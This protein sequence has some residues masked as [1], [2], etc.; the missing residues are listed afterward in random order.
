DNEKPTENGNANSKH[1][2]KSDEQRD[3]VDGFDC[4]QQGF[5]GLGI[6]GLD[7]CSNLSWSGHV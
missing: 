1:P 7:F 6:V 4:C 2:K 3:V 5:E